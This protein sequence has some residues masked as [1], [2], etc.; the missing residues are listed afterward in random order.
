MH[1][2][3][4]LAIS[5]VAV[6]ALAIAPQ[7]SAAEVRDCDTNAI[8]HCGALTQTELKNDY[9]QNTTGDLTAVFNHYGISADDINGELQMG[10]VTKQGNVEVNGK[11]IATNSHSL[12]RSAI[13]GSKAVT[14]SGKTY[15]ETPD[16]MSLRSDAVDA[17]VIMKD[18]KFQAAIMT[19]CGNPVKATPVVQP[20]PQ[21]VTYECVS[22]TAT[23]IDRLTYRFT[24]EVK[25][26]NGTKIEQ[27]GLGFGD[28]MGVTTAN[29]TY[30]YSYKEAG[31]YT[32]TIND[33]IVN[34]QRIKVQSSSKCQVSV[35][36][37]Q[38]TTTKVQPER[39]PIAGKEDLPKNSNNCREDE[40]EVLPVATPL[41][42]TG[43]EQFIGAGLGASSLTA[44]GYY[45]IRS[46][47][48]LLSELLKK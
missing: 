16:T 5:L 35:T 25:A 17:F 13:N 31:N 32:A 19:A 39:C 12:G 44:A 37:A 48:T 38:P 23:R 29:T 22:L 42:S 34:G 47:R 4:S 30:E 21:P 1:K 11:V 45:F 9:S 33:V 27:Y 2:I 36:V 14:I 6:A 40:A 8:I 24:A 41:P 20:K 18:G 15:Y 10:R 26:S 7:V 3:I 43:P 28:G 46:R